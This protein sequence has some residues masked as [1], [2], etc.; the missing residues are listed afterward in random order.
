MKKLSAIFMATALAF[1][2]IAAM[3]APASADYYG[4][5]GSSF[6]GYGF[7][8]FPGATR[9]SRTS[10]V[11]IPFTRITTMPTGRTAMRRRPCPALSGTVPNLQPGDRPLLQASRRDGALPPMTIGRC[12]RRSSP[13]QHAEDCRRHELRKAPD[14]S[15]AAGALLRAYGGQLPQETCHAVLVTDRGWCGDFGNARLSPLNPDMSAC[16]RPKDRQLLPSAH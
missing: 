6:G 11:P 5:Y 7:S 13:Y 8:G 14:R 16:R 12:R 1:G 3:S 10:S 2:T 9:T 15:S 4:S